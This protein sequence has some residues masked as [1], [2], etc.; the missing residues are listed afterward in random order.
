MMNK[1]YNMEDV[2]TFAA[3][4]IGEGTAFHPDNDFTDYINIKSGVS[5][6]SEEEVNLRNRL[7]DECFIICEKVG[8][9]IY[10][11]MLEV[12]LRETGLHNRN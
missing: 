12:Y 2:K 4:L 8:E 10:Q 1:I 9:D 6:Y 11:V 3:N 7:M 5:F